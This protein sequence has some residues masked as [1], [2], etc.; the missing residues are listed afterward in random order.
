MVYSFYKLY[1]TFDLNKADLGI[2]KKPSRYMPK[3]KELKYVDRKTLAA[4]VL[5]PAALFIIILP[6]YFGVIAAIMFYGW[7]FAMNYWGTV[8]DDKHFK[9]I[10]QGREKDNICTFSRYFDCNQ[11]DTWVIR[12]VFE[13]IQDYC[14]Q[15]LIRPDD[16]VFDDLLIDEEDYTD[17]LV[18][19]IA[20]RCGRSLEGGENNSN[21]GE[22]N[23][24]KGLIYFL[25]SQPKLQD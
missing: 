24:L 25:N 9:K 5:L 23:T 20:D 2:M 13:E 19:E 14:S 22:T 1:Y 6:R 16:N 12:A 7:Y 8:H 17:D 18:P 10:S 3:R 4:L 21:W 11:V 15:V